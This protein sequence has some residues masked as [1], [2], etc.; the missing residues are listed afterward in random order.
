MG[1]SATLHRPRAATSHLARKPPLQP[2]LPPAPHPCQ[3][4]CQQRC[5][6]VLQEGA[7][8][9]DPGA[10]AHHE[11][12]GLGAGRQP[13]RAPLHPHW[14]PHLALSAHMGEGCAGKPQGRPFILLILPCS[15]GMG[16]TG[17]R[18]WPRTQAG[19]RPYAHTSTHTQSKRPHTGTHPSAPAPGPA[20]PATSYIHRAGAA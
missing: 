1:S 16:C 8:G 15:S 14:Q 9:C 4:T 7:E 5:L 19:N 20:L 18:S 3:L 6:A 17:R 10:R 12:R 13:Q 11:Q 2:P